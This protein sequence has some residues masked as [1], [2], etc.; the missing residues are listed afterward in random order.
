MSRRQKQ[1]TTLLLQQTN[2]TK[3]NA[4]HEFTKIRR[5][6]ELSALVLLQKLIKKNLMNSRVLFTI[7]KI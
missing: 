3:A 6:I 7:S 5:H 4:V 1:L 2:S